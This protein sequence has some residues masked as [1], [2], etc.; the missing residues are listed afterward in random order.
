MPTKFHKE[1]YKLVQNFKG[2][3]TGI[4]TKKQDGNLTILYPFLESRLKMPP[5][6]AYYCKQVH[7]LLNNFL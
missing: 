7:I 6:Y 4:Q 5:N 2:G 3:Q 1:M